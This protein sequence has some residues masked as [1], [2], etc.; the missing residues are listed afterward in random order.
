MKIPLQP[1]P[2]P[3]SARVTWVTPEAGQGLSSQGSSVPAPSAFWGCNL[4]G[5]ERCEHPT[6][7]CH[8]RGM[9]AKGKGFMKYKN[10]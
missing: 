1:M 10:G 6:K 4:W 8:P 5:P 3:K 7:V 2:A 9:P